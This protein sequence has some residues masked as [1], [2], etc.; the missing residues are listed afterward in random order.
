[1][2]DKKEKVIRVNESA[3][4]DLI[5]VIVKEAVSEKKKEWIAEQKAKQAKVIEEQINKVLDVKLKKLF[6]EK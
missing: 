5:E 2:K 4:V 3:L 1:M 6:A